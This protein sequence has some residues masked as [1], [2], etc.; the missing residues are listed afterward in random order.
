MEKK[1]QKTK[2]RQDRLRW[3]WERGGPAHRWGGRMRGKIYRCNRSSI[4]NT[5]E[6]ETLAYGLNLH[7]MNRANLGWSYMGCEAEDSP[8]ATR[9]RG[10]VD[11]NKNKPEV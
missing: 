3:C 6:P 4:D 2:K 8:S 9:L 1:K 10:E 7:V 11:P 5:R